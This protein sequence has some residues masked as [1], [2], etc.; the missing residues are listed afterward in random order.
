M[1][2]VFF[3]LII[4]LFLAQITK[5]Q[6]QD[7]TIIGV[8]TI[9]GEQTVLDGAVIRVKG[10]DNYTGTQA[11]GV[12][13]LSVSS[14]DSILVCSYEGFQSKEVPITAEVEYH[15]AL[16]RNSNKPRLTA[17]EMDV[18]RPAFLKRHY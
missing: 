18:S 1:N 6:T 2:K 10:T 17:C 11:D 7:R 5:A 15:I 13:Y 9:E 3:C 4:F 8:V 12:F 14:K 16:T